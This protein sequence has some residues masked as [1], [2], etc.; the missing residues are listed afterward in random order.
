MIALIMTVYNREAYLA[1]AIKSVLAQTYTDFFFLICDDGSTDNSVDIAMTLSSTDNRVQLLQ[2]SH[3]GVSK[4]L[5]QA[6]ALS[7]SKYIG[8]VDSDDWLHP[9]ALELM[10]PIIETNPSVGVIYS[11]YMAVSENEKEIG[12]SRSAKI[13][14][15]KERL[16]VDLMSHHFRIIRRSA[17][18]EVGGIDPSFVCNYDY[19]IC[20]KLSEVTNFQYFPHV[21]YYRRMHND[22]ISGSQREKQIQYSRIA[23]EQAL[24]RRGLDEILSLYVCPDT[25]KVQLTIR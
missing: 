10:I 7:N 15:S 16:L 5:K 2:T 9:K 23:I 6:I 24:K 13:P 19:Q 12:I 25:G 20:L 14:Y 21:L 8:V 17:Y 3:Q 22:S 18:D 11:D 4:A 1:K